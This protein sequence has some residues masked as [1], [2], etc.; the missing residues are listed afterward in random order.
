MNWK[1]LDY[2]PELRPYE[3]DIDLRMSRL[4]EKEKELLADG[5][6]LAEFANGYMFFGLHKTRSGWVY[7]EWAPNADALAL[8][9]D[10]NNWN[11]KSHPLHPIGSGCWE[12]QIKGRSSIKHLTD[13]KIAVTANGE[14]MYRMPLYTYYATQNIESR[15]YNA[16]V[17]EPDEKYKW[18]DGRFKPQKNV[19]PIIYEAHVGMSGEEPKVSTYREFADNILPRI[20]EDGYNTVQLMAI[21]EHPYYGSFGYQVSNFFAA[22]SRF[23]TP[24]DL[25]YLVDTAHGLGISVLLDLVHSHS[26]KNT[27]EG[28]NC[29]DGTNGQFFKEG[30]AGNHP[31][32][33]SKVF[34]YGKNGVLHFLLTN[35]KFWLEVYHFDGFRFDGVTSM[36]YQNHGLGV[37]FTGPE[38]YFSM[39]TDVDAVT[40]LQLATEL[41]HEVKPEAVLIS[42]DMSAMPGMCLPVA[43]GGIGFDYRLSM[44]LPDFFIKTIKEYPDGHWDMGKLCWELLAKRSGEK[45]IAYAESHDQALVGDKTIMFRLADAEMYTSMSRFMQSP[46]IDRAVAL[47]KLIRLITICSGG[48]GYLNFM[49]NEFGH[50]EW[51]D[52][53]REGNGWSHAYARRQ[54][55]LASDTNLRYEFLG[56]FDKAM[57]KLI[58]DNNILAAED[59]RCIR[60]HQDN[61]MIAFERGGY[62]FAFNFH[63]WRSDPDFFIPSIHDCDVVLSS[64]DKQFDGFGLIDTSVRYKALGR[65]PEF[66]TGFSVYLPARTALVL[67]KRPIRKSKKK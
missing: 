22:S 12:V 52:F 46:V 28:I 10:F 53:P 9:G 15:G 37:S 36:I 48:E 21:M 40:Y 45:R 16:T 6:T 50:P 23:G 58:R 32:W 49:G 34:D 66:G 38:M 11:D 35:L 65:D 67:K 26:V 62:I 27:I 31:A 13:Y 43:D 44:G 17:W 59:T 25:K 29:F 54:W 47:H 2:Q 42:E 39:N 57:V 51:I 41:V 14:T 64:D 60:F 55:S 56:N 30:D 5:K 24:D 33:G 18:H 19:P 20:K 3:G 4:A 7:R 61:Q 1:I 8:V 63:P